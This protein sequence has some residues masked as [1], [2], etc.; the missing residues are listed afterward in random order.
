VLA[1]DTHA[2]LVLL[3]YACGCC[4][5]PNQ[6]EIRKIGKIAYDLGSSLASTPHVRSKRGEDERSMEMFIRVEVGHQERLEAAGYRSPKWRVLQALQSVLSATQL[7]LA[8]RVG[9]D[10]SSLLPKRRQGNSPVL[11][12][13]ARTNCLFV[14]WPG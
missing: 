12:E 14:G 11:G 13:R 3:A 8:R 7:Q 1:D 10:G 5:T 6:V 2:K 9:G 4:S